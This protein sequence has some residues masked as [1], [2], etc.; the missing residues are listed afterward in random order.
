M[1]PEW[2]A[3]VL[4]DMSV[5]GEAGFRTEIAGKLTRIIVFNDHDALAGGQDPHDLFGVKWDNP[6]HIQVIGHNTFFARQ[7]LHGFLNNPGGGAP[8]DKCRSEEHTSEL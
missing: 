1:R 8:T 7:R 2:F 3:I 4:A 5:G 6:F